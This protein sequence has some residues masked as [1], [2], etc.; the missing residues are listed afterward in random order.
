MKNIY[1]GLFSKLFIDLTKKE[2]VS[3]RFNIYLRHP[4][5]IRTISIKNYR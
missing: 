5:L 1:K 2:D 4:L 3:N